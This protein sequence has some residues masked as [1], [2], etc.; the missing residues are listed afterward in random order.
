MGDDSIRLALGKTFFAEGER[1]LLRTSAYFASLFR[2]RSGVEAVR[3]AAGRGELVWLP[4][5]GQQIWDWRIDGK[6]Q[7]FEGFVEEPA[8]GRDFLQNYGAFLIHCGITAMGNPGPNDRHLHH[9][10]LPVARFDEAWLE[11]RREGGRE[12]LSLR[13]R[14]RWHVP[15]VAEYVFEPS[16]RLSPDGL[17]M[18]VEARLENP[19]RAPLDYMYLAHINFPFAGAERLA[20]TTPFDA[21]HISVRDEGIPG[22]GA[23]PEGIKRIER[24]AN[25]EPELVA[26]LDDRGSPGGVAGSIMRYADG[27]SRWVRQGT[28][29]LDHHVIWMTHT[30]DRG[31]CGFHLPSTAGPR[32]LAAERALGN[33]KRLAPGGSAT[34]SY[35]LG[36]CD[37]GGEAPLRGAS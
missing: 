22:L 21:G 28:A 3:V 14:V 16:L 33:V 20:S 34:L 37:A 32:G 9:G 17:S 24:S 30:P 8:F 13:G 7:K 15:F 31:A 10:E 26:I 5:L 19:S 6:S 23:R 2:Y 4:F 36:Y 11:L 18:S 35:S 25:Y 29:E 27:A 12:E 1:E